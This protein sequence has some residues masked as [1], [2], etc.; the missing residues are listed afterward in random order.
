MSNSQESR[1]KQIQE[2]ASSIMNNFFDALSKAKISSDAI[3]VKRLEQTRVPKTKESPNG[4]R[5]AMFKN[6]PNKDIDHILAE[7]KTW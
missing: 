3:G 1:Q 4:F 2:Q 6:A 7:K 5:D